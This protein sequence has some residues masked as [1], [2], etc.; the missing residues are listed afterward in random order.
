MIFGG[1]K[2]SFFVQNRGEEK[3]MVSR[4]FANSDQIRSNPAIEA[5][6]SQPVEGPSGFRGQYALRS[7]FLEPVLMMKA[8]EPAAATPRAPFERQNDRLNAETT[9]ER[10]AS[11]DR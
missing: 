8:A 3:V 9:G 6:L 4:C 11:A 10:F 1:R 5:H 7:D 2:R